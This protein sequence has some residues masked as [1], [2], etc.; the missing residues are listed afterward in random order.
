MKFPNRKDKRNTMNASFSPSAKAALAGMAATTLLLSPLA[1]LTLGAAAHPAA[2][3]AP[4]KGA[5][6]TEALTGAWG[7][8]KPHSDI[9][10]TVTHLAVSKVHGRFDDFD[11]AVVSDAQKPQNSSVRFT[12]QAASIDTDQPQRDT[13]LKS[14]DFFDVAKYPTITFQSS[15]VT[16]KGNGFVAT[17]LLTLHGVSKPVVL[18]F[19]LSGPVKGPDGNLHLG[20]DTAVTLNRQ[21]Y[22]LAWSKMVEGVAMVGDD[23]NVTISLDLVKKAATTASA[24]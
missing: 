15:R 24:R 13:H 11:G 3:A 4:A 8:D 21:D 23:V 12:I 9:N 10:F 18:P 17:G 6:N 20:V 19:T 22:G 16:R 1:L 2:A 14:A 7:I 5:A